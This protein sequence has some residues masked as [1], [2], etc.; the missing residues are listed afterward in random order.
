MIEDSKVSYE[1]QIPFKNFLPGTYI[2]AEQFND[3]FSEI[4]SK[5][6]EIILK[7]NSN[8]NHAYDHNNP[9][10][11]T[12]D[13]IGVYTKQQ[14]DKLFGGLFVNKIPNNLSTCCLV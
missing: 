2:K 14:V 5:I 1:L 9:H 10:N 4:E 12:A 13:Q 11:V 3:D 6:N 7:F 8:V